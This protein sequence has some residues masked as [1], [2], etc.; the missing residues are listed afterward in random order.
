MNKQEKININ[1]E[2]SAIN[3]IVVI[4]GGFAGIRA[5]LDLLKNSKNI[6]PVRNSTY[7]FFKNIFHQNTADEISNGVRITL[8]DKNPFH[9]YHPDYYEI[10]TAVLKELKEISISQFAELHSTVA[11]HFED[12]FQNKQNIN[13]LYDAVSEIDF[14]NSF[15]KTNHKKEI[16]FDWLIV[17]AGSETNF[18][19]IPRLKELSHELKSVQDGL[20][21][22][23]G[24]DELF[25]RKGKREKISIIIAGAGF[26]GCELA[27]ELSGYIKHLLIMHKRPVASIE[28]KIIEASPTILSGASAWAQKKA[29]KRLENLGIEIL[30]DSA[31]KNISKCDNC[32]P[33]KK[34]CC[35]GNVHLENG[36]ILPFDMLIW[37]AGVEATGISKIFPAE[38]VQKKLCLKTDKHL[39]ISPFKNVFAAGDIAY[40]VSPENKIPLAMTAQTAISQGRY[41]A[42]AI[43]RKIAKK[44][45]IPYKPKQ[46]KFIIPLGGKYALAD[47][48]FIKFSGF[49][50]W[51]LKHLATLRYF[52]SILPFGFAVKLWL[53]GLKIYIKND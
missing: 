19:N 17:A 43:L 28:I 21:I 52:I 51:L 41:A 34:N 26:T 3:R 7:K 25:E 2:K 39:L 46:S 15:V 24:I 16:H 18:Y 14:E 4:G 50:A 30:S 27:G 36:D 53:R 10:A 47:L 1:I 20:N 40:C 22:R 35:K 13:F 42:Y 12:I 44:N 8:I 45:L 6:Y 38:T 29:K 37:T 32:E 11:I 49:F 48:G 23:N 5:S 33:N 31:I 9:S